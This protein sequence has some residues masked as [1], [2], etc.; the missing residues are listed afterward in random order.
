LGTEY[1]GVIPMR[2]IL[3]RE[4]AALAELKRGMKEDMQ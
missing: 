2:R 4:K 3:A 1:G